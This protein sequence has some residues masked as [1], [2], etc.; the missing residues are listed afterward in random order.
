MFAKPLLVLG[1]S[2][3]LLAAPRPAASQAA[4]PTQP[5][6]AKQ[7]EDN[8]PVAD[9]HWKREVRRA[10]DEEQF[11]RLDQIAS[12][13]RTGKS[14]LQGG[15][16]R[17][18]DFYSIVD[19]IGDDDAAALARIALLHRW[20]EAR[21]GSITPRVAL[22]GVLH[23]WAWRARGGGTA[24]KVTND[25]WRLFH[26][27]LAQAAQDLTEAQKLPETCPHLYF[28]WLTV[29]L[30]QDWEPEKMRGMF[31]QAVK[32]EPGYVLYYQLYANYLQPKWDGQPGEASAFA[33][34][35]ADRL[36]GADGDVIYFQIALIL[37][38]RGNPGLSAKEMDWARIQRGYFATR[39]R[40]GVTEHQE[41][42]MAY[43]AW[44]FRDA[45]FA[46]KQFE[47]IGEKWSKKVW[48]DQ[49]TFDKARQWTEAHS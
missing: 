1:L 19:S 14:R 42:L 37:I 12:A 27:R 4:S 17:L 38:H 6:L 39:E 48:H 41:N 40:Y 3:G 15:G 16:W 25:G 32:A 43:M 26:E 18:Q 34:S 10:V 22:G 24:D 23:R 5:E 28:E 30:G 49:A 36:G 45:A 8:A 11:A 2:L 46:Q 35:A 21:P 20:M 13:L 29:G 9:K 47:K 31:E 33:K 44:K 7:S